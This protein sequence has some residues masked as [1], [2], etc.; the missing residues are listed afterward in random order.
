MSLCVY[1]KSFKVWALARVQTYGISHNIGSDMK[2]YIIHYMYTNTCEYMYVY[3]KVL[4][5]RTRKGTNIH[6]FA[7]HLFIYKRIYD[8]KYVH[9][10]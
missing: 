2:Q 8:R 4:S 6:K 10:K 5:V 1:P 7:Q 9:F 3:R